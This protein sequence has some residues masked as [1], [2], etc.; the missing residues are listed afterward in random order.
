MLELGVPLT[1]QEA[2]AVVHEVAILSVINATRGTPSRIDADTCILTRRGDVELPQAT[3]DV[4]PDAALQLLREMLAGRETPAD[5]EALAFGAASKNLSDDLAMFSRPNRRN[6]IAG[7]VM[8]ALQ[9]EDDMARLGTTPPAMVPG[10]A[11]APLAS[12]PPAIEPSAPTPTADLSSAAEG[13]L[14]RLRE[15]VA[16]RPLPAPEPPAPEVHPDR[17]WIVRAAAAVAASVA[18]VAAWWTWS[19]S[20]PTPPEA[21]EAFVLQDVGAVPLD[22]SWHIVGRREADVELGAR[23]ASA[24]APRA[25]LSAGSPAALV[26]ANEALGGGTPALGAEPDTSSPPSAPAEP[27]DTAIAAL[28]ADTSVYSDRNTGVTPPLMMFPRMKR[29]AFPGPDDVVDGPVFEVLVDQQGTVEAVRLRGREQPGQTYYR[30]RMMLAAA[31]AWQFRP[32]RLDGR[33]V[34][35]VVRVAPES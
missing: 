13:E 31:K 14:A 5:L 6:E 32:A 8:R 7:L 17:R 15:Q 16:A 29:S 27:D 10:Q 1:W 21:A 30:A 3:D 26:A 28:F 11:T 19:V 34:R 24:V 23:S 4:A 33:P 25:D 20:P 35:Y 9:V 18:L 2:V 12:T 22:P